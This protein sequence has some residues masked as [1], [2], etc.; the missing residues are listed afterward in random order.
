MN[1]PTES[2]SK[3]GDAIFA[4]GAQATAFLRRLYGI[5]LPPERAM[6]VANTAARL[7][8]VVARARPA[9]EPIEEPAR[10]AVAQAALAKP[11][12]DAK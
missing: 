1:S 9:F 3:G 2:Q 11:E 6:E 4:S 5:T 12:G 7:C 10:F 8:D